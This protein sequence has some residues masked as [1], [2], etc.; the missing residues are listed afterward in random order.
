MRDRGRP[1][2]TVEVKGLV[3]CGTKPGHRPDPAFRDEALRVL[4]DDDLRT[5][6]GR[7]W[8][9]LFGPHTPPDV[10][11]QGWLTAARLG[12]NAIAAGVRAFHSRP[13]RGAFLRSWDGPVTVVSGEHDINPAASKQVAGGLPN[14]RFRLI[15]DVGHYI[16]LE[17]PQALTTLV[18]ELLG[19]R[20]PGAS[21]G[22][23]HP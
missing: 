17:A 8:L 16:A 9:P 3:L 7:Y 13:D 5:A 1:S 2:R 12:P 14:G 20:D 10:R 18:A 4:S 19:A 6:W 21:H 11:E 15:P 23:D 22:N